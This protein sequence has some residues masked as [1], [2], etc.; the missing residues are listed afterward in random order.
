MT[1]SNNAMS[2][3]LIKKTTTD[4]LASLGNG[5]NA[6]KHLLSFIEWTMTQD[7]L[8]GSK[9]AGLLDRIERVKDDTQA[10]KV[11]KGITKAIF[12]DARLSKSK[13]DKKLNVLK[14][15][16]EVDADA[17]KRFEAAVKTNKSFRNNLLSIVENKEPA[18]PAFDM[19]K[20]I[21]TLVA[22]NV[23]REKDT[24]CTTFD[25]I[26]VLEAALKEA[27]ARTPK[28]LTKVA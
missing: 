7:N 26:R 13:C 9:L 1:Q 22:S 21:K 2:A 16:M 8:D 28:L 24:A 3:T 20:A 14:L 12:P 17:V 5:K 18:K 25:T 10:L 4:F 11:V 27:H 15:G 6:S 19:K 23:K